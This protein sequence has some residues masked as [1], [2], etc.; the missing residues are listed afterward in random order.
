MYCQSSQNLTCASENGLDMLSRSEAKS[1]SQYSITRKILQTKS[2]QQIEVKN[3]RKYLPII[4]KYTSLVFTKKQEKYSYIIHLYIL[5]FLFLKHLNV[6]CN[7]RYC[8][9]EKTTVNQ[10]EVAFLWNWPSGTGEEDENV[11]CLQTDGPRGNQKSTGELKK[12]CK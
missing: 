8:Q 11:K 1:C 7:I 5:K 9:H 6:V 12:R 2:E 10:S 3:K 4:P